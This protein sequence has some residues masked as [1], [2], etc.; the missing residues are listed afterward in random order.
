MKK[1]LTL[2]LLLVSIS[3]LAQT[4]RIDSLL[5]DI[6]FSDETLMTSINPAKKDFLYT[7]INLNNKTFFAGREVGTNLINVSGHIYYFSSIGIFAGASGIWYDQLTPG[8]ST[9]MLTLGYGLY[10]D[11][12]KHLRATGAYSRFIYTNPDSTAIYPYENNANLSFSYKKNWYGAR[13]SSNMLFGSAAL[14]NVTPAVFTNF[15]FGKFGKNNKFY[16]GPEISCYFGKETINETT[17]PEGVFGLLNVQLY[18]P[19][20]VNIEN[21][22]LQLGY[23]LNFPFTQDTGISYQISSAFS[24]SAFY[25]IPL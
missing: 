22:E 6:I 15:Y 24:V 1:V 17:N 12:G 5:N 19:L 25:L 7:G 23:S 21:F 14:F 10:L 18:A 9:T 20:S 13:V 16:F 4:D 11:K 3:A 2:T 8:Y